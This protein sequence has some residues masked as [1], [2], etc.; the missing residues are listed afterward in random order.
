MFKIFD[1]PRSGV[2]YNIG[3][4]AL[5]LCQTIGLTSESFKFAYP[6]Y[7]YREY[8]SSSYMVYKGHRAKR[9]V[10]GLDQKIKIPILAM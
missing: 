1:H 9:K 6:V 5:S 8:G 7:L 10:T 3:R 4:S 2:V